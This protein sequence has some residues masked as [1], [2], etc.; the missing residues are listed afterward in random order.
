MRR[1]RVIE[2][3]LLST[4][5]DLGRF[6]HSAS[7]VGPAGAADALSL[8]I[9]NRL[10]GNDENAGAIEMTLR[11]ATLSFEEDAVVCLAG[12]RA[13]SAVVISGD[14][15][16]PLDSWAPTPIPSASTI[17]IGPISGGARAYLCVDGGIAVE[18]VLGSRATHVPS[19]VGPPVLKEGARLRLGEPV[20]GVQLAPLGQ[21]LRS[22][23][24]S[25]LQRRALRITPGSQHEAF[26]AEAREAIVSG[27]YT[28]GTRSDRAGIRL[29]GLPI[30]APGG[31]MR[32]EAVLTGSI[33][34]TPDGLPL[35]LFV[36]RPTTGGY[37]VLATVIGADLPRLGQ[38]CARDSVRFAWVSREE[39]RE[40]AGVMERLIESVPKP[41]PAGRSVSGDAR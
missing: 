31:S 21:S 4:V 7:G 25:M 38:L 8:R 19:A 29:E 27:E 32:S 30:S 11:G 3:G 24:D 10:L 39:A 40:A 36:D 26:A 12:V 2:P 41:Q 23:L 22:E 28:V 6:G 37:P 13:T 20:R 5:Q 17:D 35:V 15:E 9:G 18:P 33:Q 34:I 16:R 1:I 14:T